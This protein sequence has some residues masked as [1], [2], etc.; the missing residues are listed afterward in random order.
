MTSWVEGRLADPDRERK[1]RDRSRSRLPYADW[2]LQRTLVGV[3]AGL[4]LGAVVLPLP[5]IAL[6]PDLETYAGVIAAQGMLGLAFGT[7]AVGVAWGGAG[8]REILGRLGIKRFHRRAIAQLLLAYLA[9][10]IALGLYALL[11][12]AP[13]QKDIARELGLDGGVLTATASVILI[14]IVAPISEELFFRGMF[15]G[16]LRG[17][18]SFLP[19]ALISA[20]VFGSL[21]LPTGASTVPPLVLLGFLL[22][23]VYE[24]SGSLWPAIILHVINNSL[25]LA[26]AL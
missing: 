5:V 14:A 9:Y 19:A 11:L 7:T 18:M 8:W 12:G 1:D 4:F 25:A 10:V 20:T 16:G 21:H 6:D 23:W 3:L 24:R 15:F 13:E 22:A 26:V 17:R 2:P